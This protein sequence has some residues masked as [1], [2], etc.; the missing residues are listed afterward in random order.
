MELYSKTSGFC[1]RDKGKYK[2]ENLHFSYRE[3]S[4]SKEEI[5]VSAEF[6]C[7][8]ED[9][10]KIKI[11]SKIASN[12]RKQNQPLKFRSAG[13]IFKNPSI[14]V[15]AGYLIDK[16]GLKGTRIGGAII[17]DKHANF[18]LN[19]DSAKLPVQLNLF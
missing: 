17:S 9:I 10:A 13:S 3:S 8:K 11:N 16:A 5:I 14:D 15:S 19:I 1:W 7:K 12:K 2:R 6:S 4:F 18:I